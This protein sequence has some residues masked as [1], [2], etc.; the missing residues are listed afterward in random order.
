VPEADRLPTAS[1]CVNLLK[2]PVY[3]DAATLRAKL[4]LA[5]EADTGFEY[6]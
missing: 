4:L 1:T 2:L 6:S 5:L 3:P